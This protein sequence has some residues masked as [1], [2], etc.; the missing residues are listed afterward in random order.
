MK[1]DLNGERTR[2]LNRSK[3]RIGIVSKYYRLKILSNT[4]KY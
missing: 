4:L 2:E 3:E 1:R